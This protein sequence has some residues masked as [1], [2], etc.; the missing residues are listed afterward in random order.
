M[1]D[2][3][4]RA[5][6]AG[7]PAPICIR[8][9]GLP[10]AHDVGAGDRDVRRAWARARPRTISGSHAG[11]RCP[12]LPQHWSASASGTSSSPG[13]AREHGERR[14]GDA[15]RVQQVAG[16]VVG[17]RRRRAAPPARGPAAASSSLTSRT[18]AA[19]AAARASHAGSSASRCPYS[20]M[21]APQPAA[22]TAT[23]S[24]PLARTPRCCAR[25]SVRAPCRRRRRAR[26]ARRSSPGPARRH[27]AIA[28]HGER[29]L[30]RARARARTGPPSRSRRAARRR[31]ATPVATAAAYAA[32]GMRRLAAPS[33]IAIAN[34]RAPGSRASSSR[35]RP[36]ADSTRRER[37]ARRSMTGRRAGARRIGA[38][39]ARQRRRAR[40]V[41]RV[42]SSRCAV[43]H[44]GR[45]RGLA[46]AAAEAAVEVRLQRFVSSASVPSTTRAHQ[47]D[48]A[49]RAVVL[50]LEREV[51]RA[52]LQAEAAVHAGVEAG[53]LAGER[54]AGMAQAAA[55][56]A[57]CVT[58]LRRGCRDSG[59]GA[60]RTRRAHG[61]RADRPAARGRA[62]ASSPRAG[63]RDHAQFV[64][65]S[66]S[67]AAR[68][69]APLPRA[70]RIERRRARRRAHARC[71]RPSR[72]GGARASRHTS[73]SRRDRGAA[74]GA[75]RAARRHR[76]RA[77][78]PTRCA[79]SSMRRT[80]LG[81][82]ARCATTAS[83]LPP[84]RTSSTARAA[85]AD[86]AGERRA[87][88]ARTASGETG[89]APQPR[90]AALE[91]RPLAHRRTATASVSST[92]GRA[93]SRTLTSVMTPS[94]P[95]EPTRSRVRS[96]PATFFTTRPP[97]R[98]TAPVP[99]RTRGRARGRAAR[100]S[101]CASGPAWRVANVAPIV[102]SSPTR[103]GRSGHHC[104][105]GA[106]G[107]RRSRRA[108]CRRA[109]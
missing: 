3:C 13:I 75:G 95:H 25:A 38:R 84:S 45:A 49:A 87:R 2:A 76:P 60:D 17:D 5:A 88:R 78:R 47:H 65:A 29:A 109:R 107:A 34:R 12:A 57:G 18:L 67:S 72:R 100:R 1:H 52:G 16:S 66:A 105:C 80:E 101:A 6:R 10:V 108:S 98:I 68:R 59:C 36:R 74:T 20:F 44:A 40:S 86:A 63:A 32:R 71:A 62:R 26:A 70:R 24:A 37:R 56:I 54:R 4:S 96:K 91:R 48:A 39:D 28:V 83:A 14:R 77:A 11:C 93:R 61:A 64:S 8:Q 53:A 15:L 55:P 90:H 106:G 21:A 51:R 79:P 9:P 7:G 73:R 97:A 69:D 103:T 46:R 23:N 50:V 81:E 82:R 99:S 22:F 19:N 31:R 42:A 102:P 92:S 85:D 94:V 43:R 41:S 33:S 58:T 89:A 104:P 35:E 30:R 27:D